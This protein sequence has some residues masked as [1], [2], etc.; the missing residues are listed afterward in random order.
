VIVAVVV[1]AEWQCWGELILLTEEWRRF[2]QLH[3]S[4]ALAA[5]LAMVE[6]VTV[7]RFVEQKE[8]KGVDGEH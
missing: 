6:F 1:I 2:P 8:E 3:R 7:V 4:F 5:T